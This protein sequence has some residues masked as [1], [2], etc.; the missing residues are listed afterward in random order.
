M[1]IF[2]IFNLTC[3]I[4]CVK[5]YNVLLYNVHCTV[6]NSALQLFSDF[7]H[8]IIVVEIQANIFIGLSCFV[9]VGKNNFFKFFP[10]EEQGLTI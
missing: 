5:S 4:I 3:T 9:T 7:L 2:T 8:N 6:A 10:Y 1:T